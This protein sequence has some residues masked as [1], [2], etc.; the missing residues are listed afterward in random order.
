MGLKDIFYCFISCL[1]PGQPRTVATQRQLGARGRCR[2][3]HSFFTQFLKRIYLDACPIKQSS[4]IIVLNRS[5]K[6]QAIPSQ[7]AAFADIAKPHKSN[8]CNYT[9]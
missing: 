3:L 6:P 2:V 4:Q 8:Y 7:N 1:K 5:T 9:A